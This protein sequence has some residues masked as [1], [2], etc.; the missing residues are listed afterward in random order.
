ML[1]FRGGLTEQEAVGYARAI[2][3]LELYAQGTAADLI[4]E[5]LRV[6]GWR[7][8]V[9]AEGVRVERIPLDS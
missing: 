8:V 2:R 9:S 6:F 3:D 4:R 7:I 1:S 5:E